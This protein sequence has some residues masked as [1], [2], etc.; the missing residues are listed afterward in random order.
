MC[1]TWSCYYDSMEELYPISYGSCDTTGATYS[2][3]VA[4]FLSQNCLG[5]HSN[6]TNSGGIS[7]EGHA[8]AQAK[9]LNGQLL[10]SI[11]HQPGYSAM[12]P[13]GIKVDNCTY[14]KIEVWVNAGA[15]N[16]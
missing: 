2:S 13:S 1:C 14:K 12:P 3:F 6:A 5:C 11:G 7:L 15:L 9:A 8:N 4:P 10:G 16:N